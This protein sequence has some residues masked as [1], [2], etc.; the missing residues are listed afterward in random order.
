MNESPRN[1]TSHARELYG[2]YRFGRFS[3]EDARAQFEPLLFEMLE[4]AGPGTVLYDVGC[5]VGYWFD[6][7]LNAG[8]EKENIVG[9]DLAPANVRELQERGFRA[10]NEN[11]AHLSVPSGVADLTVCIG[12]INCAEEPFAV[13]RELVRITRPGG[14]IYVNVYNKLHPYYY[15]VHKATWPLRYLYW[16]WSRRVADVAYALSKPLFQPLAYLALGRFLD[17]ATGKT[18]FMDQVITPRAHLYTKRMLR[19]YARRCGCTI[20]SF[21]YNRYGL[22]LAAELTVDEP[23]GRSR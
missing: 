22:M 12:V 4:S 3:Y 10:L 23:A 16:H 5:G 15:V 20:R 8:I 1:V 7:Y 9:I 18:M 17:D 13:F 11:A 21:R 19:D 2:E 6:A 14:R